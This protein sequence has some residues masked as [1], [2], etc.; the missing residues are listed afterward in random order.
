MRVGL[1]ACSDPVRSW[2]D[3]RL[4]GFRAL[5]A[6]HG[7]SLDERILADQPDASGPTS[8][9]RVPP[10]RRARL[11]HDLF[12]DDSID[13][14]ADVSG[15]NLANEVLDFLDF[16]LIGAHPKPYVGFSDN[17][18]VCLALYEHAGL[19]PVLWHADRVLTRGVGDLIAIA[20]GQRTQPQLI[21]DST[22][23]SAGSPDYP[24]VILGGNIR[25]TAKLAGTRYWP[26]V[27]D[28]A[29]IILEG[30][31]ISLPAA[32]TY[33]TQLRHA[34][35]F[36][37]ADALILGQFTAIDKSNARADLVTVAHEITELPIW[38]APEVGHSQNCAPVT[39]G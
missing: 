18:V 25:C 32:A 7:I 17:S 14:I 8:G 5:L 11:V 16:E 15:G 10:Q 28:G 29:W 31:S 24:S 13:V 3:N 21:S 9:W 33:L 1:A 39:L 38:H 19:R 34:G 36:A 22:L 6:E 4:P 30:M 20:N 12:I 23:L 27:P 37:N 2:I 35:L 26:T